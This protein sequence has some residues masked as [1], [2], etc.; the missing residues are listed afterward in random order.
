MASG[1]GRRPFFADAAAKARGFQG[2]RKIKGIAAFTADI[3]GA[4]ET[5]GKAGGFP[6]L[7]RMGIVQLLIP[8][9]TRGKH[10]E[11]QEIVCPS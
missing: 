1:F 3:K 8:D 2:I 7:V 5:A 4:R 6:R 11:P 9:T 10:S